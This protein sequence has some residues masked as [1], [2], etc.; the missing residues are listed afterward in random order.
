MIYA[1]SVALKWI[2]NVTLQYSKPNECLWEIQ[3]LASLFKARDK[4]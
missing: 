2:L 3:E 1:P 4:G